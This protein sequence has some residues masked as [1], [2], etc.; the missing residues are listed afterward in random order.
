VLV[1]LWAA[2][3]D[4]IIRQQ[5][6]DY[7][8]E[9]RHVAPATTGHTLEERGLKPGPAYGRILDALRA[10]RLDGEIE[11]PAGEARLLDRLLAEEAHETP[12]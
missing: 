4:A 9:Y 2:A 8:R 12:D 11:T 7:A 10:A 3:P 5:I 1:T 6:V